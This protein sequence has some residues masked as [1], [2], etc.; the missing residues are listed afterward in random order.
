M[1]VNNKLPNKI[2]RK[3]YLTI[4]LLAQ[5]LDEVKQLDMQEKE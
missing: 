5:N 2:S 4:V 1:T 3:V